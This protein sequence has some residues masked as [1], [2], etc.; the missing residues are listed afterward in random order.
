MVV[1]HLAQMQKEHICL[2]TRDRRIDALS[3]DASQYLALKRQ[4]SHLMDSFGISNKDSL[5]RDLPKGIG[6][7]DKQ[8]LQ[9]AFKLRKLVSSLVKQ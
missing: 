5:R 1:Y 3:D 6:R 2:Q 4:C 9:L 8:G 7:L